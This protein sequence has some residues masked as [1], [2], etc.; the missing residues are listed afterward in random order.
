MAMGQSYSAG[1]PTDFPE[2]QIVARS[3]G[4]QDLIL[5][6]IKGQLLCFLDQCAHQPVKLSEFG[7]MRDGVLVCHAHGGGFDLQR[8]GLVLCG[9]PRD[10]LKKFECHESQAESYVIIG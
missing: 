2:G 4:G 7:E 6:R 10:P 3:L 1:K 8:G 5:V 9:P